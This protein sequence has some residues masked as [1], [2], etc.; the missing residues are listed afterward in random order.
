MKRECLKCET[1]IDKCMGFV[2]ARDILNEVELPRELCAK[3]ALI[4]E[5]DEI[6]GLLHETEGRSK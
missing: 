1:E 6:D 4:T 2:I 5:L 3:C